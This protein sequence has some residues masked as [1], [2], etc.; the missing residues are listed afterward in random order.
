VNRVNVVG[1][2]ISYWLNSPGI[3]S[4]S[5]RYFQHTSRPAL[6]PIQPLVQ[7]EPSFFKGGKAPR[8]VVDHPALSSAEVKE[9]SYTFIPPLGLHGLPEGELYLSQLTPPKTA[10]QNNEKEDTRTQDHDNEEQYTHLHASFISG[11]AYPQIDSFFRINGVG[12]ISQKNLSKTWILW[13]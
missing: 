8:R 9:Q 12:T 11:N 6:G 10:I 7:W 4:R 3:A 5:G 2:A 13:R 1:I